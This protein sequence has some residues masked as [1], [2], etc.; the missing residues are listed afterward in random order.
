M[1]VPRDMTGAE[2]R[3]VTEFADL[4]RG[5]HYRSAERGEISEAEWSRRTAA[6][7]RFALP[8][9]RE[10]WLRMFKAIAEGSR[11]DGL[12]PEQVVEDFQSYMV[13]KYGDP[14]A[15]EDCVEVLR[16][17]A[18]ELLDEEDAEG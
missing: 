3:E 14:E 9:E 8:Y 10:Q 16:F 17:W 7:D 4:M 12:T 1:K 5:V 2:L 6:V 15:A 13:E 18:S 11:R